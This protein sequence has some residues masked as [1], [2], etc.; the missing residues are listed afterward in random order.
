MN[1]TGAAVNLPE[2]MAKNQDHDPHWTAMTPVFADTSSW[3]G[4]LNPRDQAHQ[5]ALTLSQ[6]R[7]E[8]IV[9]TARVLTEVGDAL[10]ELA[11][12][13]AFVQFMHDLRTDPDATVIPPSRS[14]RRGSPFAARLD[15]KWSFTDCTSFV[16]MQKLGLLETSQAPNASV[17]RTDARKTAVG[18]ASFASLFGTMWPVG[19]QE[20]TEDTE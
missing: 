10:S 14:G 15:K 16:V 17:C 18:R 5:E 9:T 4:L 3:L 1:V 20:P 7:S 8:P 6:A 19:M 13:A 11:N 12:R 2:D